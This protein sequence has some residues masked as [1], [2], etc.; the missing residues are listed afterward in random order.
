MPERDQGQAAF[1][2]WWRRW[3]RWTVVGLA[4]LAVGSPLLLAC[5]AGYVLRAGYEEARVLWRREPI[6]QVLA[7]D[8]VAGDVRRK[9]EAVLAARAFSVE[10]GLEPRGSFASL[11]YIDGDDN[12]FVV[13]AA[14]RT[15]LVPYTWWF[16]V[17]GRVPYKGF[18][19]R[20]GAEAE[21]ER[22]GSLGYDT[23]VRGAAA[24]STLGW[25]DDPLFRHLLRQDEGFLVNL[26]LHEVLHNS[27]Y[28]RG[29]AAPTFNESLASFAGHRGAVAFFAARGEQELRERA[30]AAWDDERRFADFVQALGAQLRSAYA[31][32]TGETTKLVERER[33]FAA[34]R[35]ELQGIHFTERRYTRLLDG[36]LNNAVVLQHLVYTT[37][38]DLFEEVY[39]RHGDLRQA[40]AFIARAA[41]GH[42]DDPFK[43][44]RR[45]LED[46]TPNIACAPWDS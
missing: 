20:R 14:P 46:L 16:P 40:L 18:F 44:L 11:S 30:E 37:G 1:R 19:E 6:A 41:R 36:P 27:F 24:F 5:S 43:A 25:F 42:G 9:L 45:A 32:S 31:S 21:A 35:V 2:R 26:V 33:I 34:A 12:I 38:F 13:A 8:D 17:V 23:H 28:L 10:L 15:A 22:L 29:A 7:R 3:A 4:A 39:R